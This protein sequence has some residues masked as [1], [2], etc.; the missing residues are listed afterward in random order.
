MQ[1]KMKKM[2]TLAAAAAL[3]LML[4]ITALADVAGMGYLMAGVVIV[5][6]LAIAL[7]IAAAAVLIKAILKRRHNKDNDGK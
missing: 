4:S 5:P 3:S 7:L 2:Y 6:I 1:R